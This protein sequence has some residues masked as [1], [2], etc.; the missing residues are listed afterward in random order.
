MSNRSR[1]IEH[2]SFT[3][4]EPKN[5]L[6]I[7]PSIQKMVD[8]VKEE[9]QEN[10]SEPKKISDGFKKLMM[11]GKLSDVV[12]F[13]DISIELETLNAAKQKFV[14]QKM[15][16]LEQN[17]RIYYIRLYVL[18]EAILNVN[19]QPLESLMENDN[20]SDFDHKVEIL[21][22]MQSLLLE[23]LYEKYNELL[24]KSNN[25]FNPTTPEVTD[26]LKN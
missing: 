26:N 6:N 20:K 14:I 8:M 12:T 25:I 9:P 23:K 4:N 5:N 19:G 3:R 15:N 17:E 11:F 2:G 21:G 24:E 1:N 18:A 13:G 22:N 16:A 10:I 7:S